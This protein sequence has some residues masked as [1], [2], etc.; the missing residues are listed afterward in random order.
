[1]TPPSIVAVITGRPDSLEAVRWAA[2]LSQHS[3]PSAGR[4]AAEQCHDGP[5]TSMDLVTGV[6]A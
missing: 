6:P 5:V 4:A 1:M 3:G 2:W